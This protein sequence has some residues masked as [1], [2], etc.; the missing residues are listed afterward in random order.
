[1]G[2]AQT[3]G[4]GAYRMKLNDEKLIGRGEWTRVYKI[5]RKDNSKV[6]AAKIFEISFEE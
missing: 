3:R 2:A 1:M 6:C 5:L 4:E